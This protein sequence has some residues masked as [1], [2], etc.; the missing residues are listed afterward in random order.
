MIDLMF[1]PI[2]ELRQR[3]LEAWQ[4]RVMGIVQTRDTF[5]GAPFMHPG[6]TTAKMQ[7]HPPEVQ[8]LLRTTLN[9]TFFTADHLVHRDPTASDMCRFC[10]A[11]DSQVHRHWQCPFFADCRTHLSQE[12]IDT[13]LTMPK[14]LLNHAWVPTPPS[15]TE[16]RRQ[17]LMIPD[18]TTCFAWPPCLDQHL[19]LFTDGSCLDP[20]SQ[21][22]KLASWGLALGS[23][24]SD[25]FVPVSNGLLPGWTQTAPR[26]E[27]MAVLGACEFALSVSRPCTIWVDNDRVYNKLKRFMSGRCK[28][29]PNH[30]DADLWGKLADCVARLG[31]LLEGIGN[32]VSHQ[33]LEGAQDEAEQWIFRGNMAAD[34]T[35]EAAYRRFPALLQQWNALR[36][37]VAD[38]CVLREQVH[39]VVIAVGK[40]SILQPVE[41]TDAADHVPRIQ[42]DQIRAFKPEPQPEAWTSRRFK[43]DNVD[44]IV[45][46]LNALVDFSEPLRMISWFDLSALF[47]H[48]TG[49]AGIEYRPSSKRSLTFLICESPQVGSRCPLQCRGSQTLRKT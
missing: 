22:S 14:V 48:A 46:W 35:A 23:V 42:P 30:K 5:E 39:K 19:H 16:F 7:S 47:E 27:I 13:L 49:L 10:G 2:Q 32:V 4:H 8:A 25:K 34:A 33:N 45:N 18:E 38:V 17:C 44:T 12:Q 36:K 9:G 43:L 37:D 1:C 26:A 29:G 11:K 28:I 21:T 31:A 20:T 6:I 15:L 3:L 40:K 24:T 41:Q